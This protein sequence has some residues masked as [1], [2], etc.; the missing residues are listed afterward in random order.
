MSTFT[1]SEWTAQPKAIH[2]GMVCK[3]GVASV[4]LT[5]T[6]SSVFKLV[7]VPNHAT[8]VDYIWYSADAG[9]NQTYKL[10]MRLPISDT[11]TVTE[12]CLSTDISNTG[13]QTHRGSIKLPYKVSFT[14]NAIQQ[15]AW[16]EAVAAAAISASATHRFTVFYTMDGS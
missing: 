6:A 12:S 2:A 13:G 1:A 4:A 10:G 14:D 9:A 8:I 11:V 5:G 7:K 16:I 3:S 15:W